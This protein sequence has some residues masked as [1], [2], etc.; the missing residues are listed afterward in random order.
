M[1]ENNNVTTNNKRIAKNTVALYCRMFLTIALQLYAVPIVLRT[2]GVD[3]YGLYSV[4][5][6][7][8]ALFSFVGSSMASGA[9]R[10]FAFAIGEGNK[11]KMVSLFNTTLT[12]YNVM[13]LATIFIFEVIGIWFIEYKMQIPEGRTLAAHIVFQFSIISFIIGLISVPYNAVVIAHEK[14]DIFAYIS[15]GSSLLKLLSVI[16]LQFIGYDHLITYALLMLLVSIIERVFYQV[17]CH[18]KFEECKQYKW[19]FDGELGK[20]MLTYSGF[21]M[22]GAIAMVLRRQGLNILMNLFF[23]TLLNAA[24]AIASQISGIVEQFVSNLYVASRPQITKY[25]ASGQIQQMWTLTFRSSVLAYYLVMMVAIAAIIEMPSV[26]NIWLTEVPQY[27]VNISRLFLVCL[28]METATNQLIGVF[29]AMNQIK[30]YQIFSS[31]VLLLNVP[32]A[33]VILKFNSEDPL[34]P[35]YIQ[36]IFSFFY[37]VSLLIV[38]KKVSGLNIKTFLSNVLFREI[39]VTCI[40]M[41]SS[42]YFARMFSPSL[43]RIFATTIM[44]VVLSICSILVI[45]V[46]KNDRKILITM[47]K[48]KL[49]K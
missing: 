7:F 16:S 28:L 13:S 39:L 40:V 31:S 22:I 14:M 21:N 37:V 24:H 26:L 35:Y 25:Y 49:V 41:T 45:G 29:Q 23:G 2:L 30:W 43:I 17:Y 8:T 11:D 15:I 20:N 12:I 18:L 42:Y 3:D 27:T 10:F 48:N 9:Q 32:V 34:I 33:Y 6:G 46:D 47:I 4:I 5:G 1:S 44:V 19:T 36:A 38:S